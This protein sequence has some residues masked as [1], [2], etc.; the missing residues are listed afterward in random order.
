MQVQKGFTLIELMIVVAIIG[1]LAAFAFPAYERYMERGR[2]S[3][4]RAML[5]DAAT[6]MERCYSQN[7]TYENCGSVPGES[8]TGIYSLDVEITDNGHGFLL[9]AEREQNQGSNE[10]GDLT[11]DHAGRRDSTQGDQ[12]SCW[13]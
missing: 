13:S 3:E 4:G 1:V 9:T 8:E 6:R 11:L 7:T 10:C 2:L 12:G 5:M